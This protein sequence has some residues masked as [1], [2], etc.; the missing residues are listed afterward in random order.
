MLDLERWNMAE[1]YPGIPAAPEMPMYE[2]TLA[3]ARGV[4]SV[5]VSALPHR[6]TVTEMLVA[7]KNHLEHQLKIVNE[8]L[9]QA[10]IQKDAMALIDS[11][12]KAQIRQEY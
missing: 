12:A 2:K 7:K 5:P 4:G 3:E 1:E 8:A 6:P 11:I 9:N 10:N